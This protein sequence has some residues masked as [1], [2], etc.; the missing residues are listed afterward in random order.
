MLDETENVVS[1]GL[2]AGAGY[3][4]QNDDHYLY[5]RG[6]PNPPENYIPPPGSSVNTW[7]NIYNNLLDMDFCVDH[8]SHLGNRVKCLETFHNAGPMLY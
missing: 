2:N 7:P 1:D 8:F 4:A 3:T 6:I 5:F